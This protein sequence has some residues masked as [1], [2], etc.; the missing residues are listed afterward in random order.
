MKTKQ[1]NDL[2]DLTS[3][4]YAKNETKLLWPIGPSA[5][6]DENQTG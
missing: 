1:N 4:V 2:A 5:I 3:M 6:F